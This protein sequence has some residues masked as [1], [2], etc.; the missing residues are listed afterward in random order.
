M[1]AT[2]SRFDIAIEA[3][4]LGADASPEQLDQLVKRIEQSEQVAKLSA[5]FNE[6]M[7][8][9]PEEKAAAERRAGM[10]PDARGSTTATRDGAA[11]VEKRRA[12]SRAARK[13]RRRARR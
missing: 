13:A 7:S 10:A 2:E 11:V 4:A 1:R 6:A 3:S 12:K 5:A 8:R 9:S